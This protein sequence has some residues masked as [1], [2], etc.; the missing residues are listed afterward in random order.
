MRKDDR[1]GK[2]TL[3]RR[4]TQDRDKVREKQE[5]RSWWWVIHDVRSHDSYECGRQDGFDEF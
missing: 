4:E 3:E 5:K 2:E 1:K